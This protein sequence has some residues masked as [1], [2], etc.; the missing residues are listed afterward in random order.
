MHFVKGANFSKVGHLYY[1]CSKGQGH[2]RG[3]RKECFCGQDACATEREQSVYF[4]ALFSSAFWV[5]F[6]MLHFDFNVTFS[7]CI[8]KLALNS[9]TLVC[10]YVFMG[11]H[12]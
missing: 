2:A 5:A 1:R 9:Q 6:D 8:V 4:Q 10:E 3:L 12:P 7:I 11:R